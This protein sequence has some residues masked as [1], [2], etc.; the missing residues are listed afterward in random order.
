MHFGC[1][2]SKSLHIVLNNGV[3]KRLDKGIGRDVY[4]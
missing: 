2:C 4:E 3:H 1:D